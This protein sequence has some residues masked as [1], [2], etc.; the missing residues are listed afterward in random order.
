MVD[1][2][3]YGF[4]GR[5]RAER[6]L[7]LLRELGLAHAMIRLDAKAGEHLCPDYLALNPAGKVPSLI[8]ADKVLTESMAI[9]RFLCELPNVPRLIPESGMDRYEFE[10]RLYFALTEI[11][12]YL[13]LSDLELFIHPEGIPAGTSEFALS[14]VRQQL[15]YVCQWLRQADYIAG[16]QFSLADILYYHLLSWLGMFQADLDDSITAYMHRLEARPA[17]PASMAV[18]GTPMNT[19]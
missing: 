4:K 17:F 5:S 13:W 14:Q 1:I 19:G 2:T 12:P 9:C 16:N 18:A 10:Q 6:V 7:W 11:E 8:Y 3:L 15:P